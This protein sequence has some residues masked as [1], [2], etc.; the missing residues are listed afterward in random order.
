MKK[1][2][3]LAIGELNVDIILTGLKSLPVPGREI[4]CSDC[5]QVLGSSTAICA[6]AISRLGLE[7]GFIGKVGKDNWG[8]EVVKALGA[9]GVDTSHVIMDESARTGVTVSLSLPSDRAMVTY[10][11]TIDKF[12]LEDFDIS[13]I[14]R[15][16]H[17]HVGSFFLQNKLRPGLVKL[18]SSARE[19]GISTSLDAGWDDT[20]NWDYGIFGVLPYTSIFLPNEIEA[21]N[22]SGKD[23][24]REALEVLGKYAPIVAVKC[25]SRG[26]IAKWGDRVEEVPA[27][28]GIEPVDTTG[29]GDCFNAGFIYAFL[30]GLDLRECLT[31]GNACGA[32]SVTKVGGASSC[33]TLA[34]VESLIKNGKL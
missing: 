12:G 25:G 20:Q 14:E 3:V 13:L 4:I 1:Y 29:A 31:Y 19:K 5:S 18:F 21:L 15:A 30:K 6:S 24:V 16:R 10:M 23:N 34:E 17:I 26:A 9:N 7:V 2:D 32:I 22:I 27:F 11:G 8:E 33:P 28:S